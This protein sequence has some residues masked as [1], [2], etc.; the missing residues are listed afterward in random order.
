MKTIEDLANQFR[1]V[2]LSGKWV[3]LTNLKE[4]LSNVTWQQATTKIGSLNT[5]ALLAYHINY[6]VSGMLNV[7]QGG[8]LDIKDKYSFN[9]PPI[10]SEQDWNGLLN[11]MWSDA[12]TFANVLERMPD[13]KM[14]QPFAD[15][16]YGSY[17]KN[18]DALIGH[19]YYHL[20]Q[21]VLIKKLMD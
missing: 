10:T 13:E 8:T 14:Q 3:V 20:G 15:E 18:I 21:I 17:Q 16:K 11:K 12:E 19:I 5:I 9:A 2:H 1:E 4:Q 7:L 6:Y